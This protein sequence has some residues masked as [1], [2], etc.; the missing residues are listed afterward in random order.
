[1]IAFYQM[2]PQIYLSFTTVRR[3]LSGDVSALMRIHWFLDLHGLINF[4]VDPKQKPVNKELLRESSY[5]KV[6]INAASKHFL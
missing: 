4:K 3:H 6:L 1:M 5:E 2:D